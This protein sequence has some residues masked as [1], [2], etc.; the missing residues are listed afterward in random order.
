MRQRQAFVVNQCAVLFAMHG[1][2]VMFVETNV[3]VGELD[4]ESNASIHC[5]EYC[6]NDDGIVDHSMLTSSIY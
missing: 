1:I 6:V 3:G 2:V 5:A 4:K